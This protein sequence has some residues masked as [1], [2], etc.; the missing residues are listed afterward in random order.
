M[1]VGLGHEAVSQAHMS[2]QKGY[3]GW[4]VRMCMRLGIDSESTIRRRARRLGDGGKGQKQV[5]KGGDGMEEE[6]EARR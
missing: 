1:D 6:S 5:A 3:G 4:G 2:M